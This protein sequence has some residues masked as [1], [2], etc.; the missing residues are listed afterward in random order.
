MRTRVKIRVENWKGELDGERMLCDS[1]FGE[2]VEIRLGCEFFVVL[3]G[4][5]LQLV[6][7]WAN[8][9]DMWL[10]V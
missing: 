8:G 2:W 10:L 9:G 7:I 3:L 5:G 6:V 1:G 4:E